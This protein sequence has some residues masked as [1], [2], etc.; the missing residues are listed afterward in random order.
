MAH[1]TKVRTG[2]LTCKKRKIKCDEAK[3]ACARCTSTSRQCAGYEMEHQ[4]SPQERSLAWY[5][6]HQLIAHDQKEGRA[7]HYFARVVGPALSG[8]Q[9]AYFW[10]HLVM[11]FGHFAPAVRHAVLAISSLHEDFQNGKRITSELPGNPFALKHYNA[12]LRHI[13]AAQDESLVLLTCVLYLCVAFLL[14]DI[15]S[16][17]RHCRY[18]IAIIAESGCSGWARDHL[19]PIFRRL[20]ASPFAARAFR[21]GAALPLDFDMTSDLANT[22]PFVTVLEAEASLC[23]LKNRTHELAPIGPSSRQARLNPDPALRAHCKVLLDRWFDRVTPLLE[24]PASSPAERCLLCHLRASHEM[25]R[26]LVDIGGEGSEMSFD[27]HTESFR[28]IMELAEEAAALKV[29]PLVSRQPQRA[30]FTFEPGLLPIL[31]FTSSRCRDLPIRLK[32]LTL[33]GN[34]VAAKEGLFDVGTMYRVGRRV[35]EMEH[36]MSLEDCVRAV[37]ERDVPYPPEAM[38][39]FAA[40]FDRNLRVLKGPDGQMTYRRSIN[41]L[42]RTPEGPR[43]VA[44]EYLTDDMPIHCPG[45]P[46][47]RSA[48]FNSSIEAA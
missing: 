41:M 34:I 11:Q 13:Q 8:P 33:M 35:T 32:A 9:D 29:A 4:R 16:V 27:R 46:S 31:A 15:D 23:D 43:V 30:C 19:L 18:G 39:I 2:C 45:I 28:T 25:L 12:S 36:G 37:E 1:G 48:L 42:V 17:T 40:D 22:H 47:M 6:P 5:R 24:S 21:Q 38:R 44:S 26:I 20:H 7:F 14:G 3:P 10:T